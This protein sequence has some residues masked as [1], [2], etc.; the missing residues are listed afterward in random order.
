MQYSLTGHWTF[1]KAAQKET[2]GI[3]VLGVQLQSIGN[4]PRRG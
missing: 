4:W 2:Q 3:H 1:E